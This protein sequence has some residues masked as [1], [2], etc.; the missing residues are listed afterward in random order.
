MQFVKPAPV[1]A[2][3]I[4]Y[5]QAEGIINP[6]MAEFL[7]KG[8][9]EAGEKK[10]EAFIIQ[11]DTPG[12]LDLSMRDIIK[13]ILSSDVPVVVYVAPAGSRAASAGVFITYAANVAA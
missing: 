13:G 4:H 6:V 8:L 1:A 9:K 12:G 11:L 5:V 2:G 10:A 3:E 7:A